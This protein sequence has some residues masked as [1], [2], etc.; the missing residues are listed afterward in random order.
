MPPFTMNRIFDCWN[1]V[2]EF[3]AD[4]SG[5]ITGVEWMVGLGGGGD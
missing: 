5:V 2:D 3:S 4:I 1:D